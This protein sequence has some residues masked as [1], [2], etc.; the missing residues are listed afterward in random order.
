MP[1]A[2][3]LTDM[4]SWS[5]RKDMQRRAFLA[6]RASAQEHATAVEAAKPRPVITLR[7]LQRDIAT[8]AALGGVESTPASETLRMPRRD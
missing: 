1:T 3:N 5:N 2:D 6:N 7:S 4:D 8:A